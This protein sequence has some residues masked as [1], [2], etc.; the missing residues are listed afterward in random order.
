MASAIHADNEVAPSSRQP[1]RRSNSPT[2]ATKRPWCAATW[3]ASALAQSRSSALESAAKV[4]N[5]KS[6]AAPVSVPVW[7][8]LAA[9]EFVRPIDE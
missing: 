4:R 9:N 2:K 7:S 5:V 3:R 6:G 8:S 1:W